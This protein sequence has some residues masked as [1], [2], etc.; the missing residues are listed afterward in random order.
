VI[1]ILLKI[2]S[3]PKTILSDSAYLALE[4]KIYVFG[5]K[6]LVPEPRKLVKN[7]G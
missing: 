5:L 2:N 3:S 6:G 1:F 7:A 4:V